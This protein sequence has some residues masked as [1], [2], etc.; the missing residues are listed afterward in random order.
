MTNRTRL[1]SI[2][3]KLVLTEMTKS[4]YGVGKPSTCTELIKELNKALKSVAGD[5]ASAIENPMG[6]KIVF[7][8]G[9]D[10]AS[11]QVE[12]YRKT[13]G[14]DLFDLISIFHGSDRVVLKNLT[15]ESVLAFI[16][17]NLDMEKNCDSY[18]N[19]A[20]NKGKFPITKKDDKKCDTKKKD[21]EEKISD[22]MEDSEEKTQLDTANKS[23]KSAI[24]DS[25]LTEFGLEMGGEL[26]DKIE[27]IIDRVLKGKQVKSDSK[28]SYLKADSEMESPD[29][30][31]VKN[32]ETP[33]LKETVK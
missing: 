12:L 7:D 25:K 18:V 24:E 20:F 5:V 3:K 26:V 17:D 19:K 15:K 21:S 14:G 28:T 9:K 10:G 13:D 4:D 22:A 32:K 23:T 1:K 27:K 33:K 11:F 2:I 29:K 31:T 6:N 8:D 16:K 30:L